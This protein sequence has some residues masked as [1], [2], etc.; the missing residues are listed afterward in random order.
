MSKKTEAWALIR[1]LDVHLANRQTECARLLSLR[2]MEIACSANKFPPLARPRKTFL[3]AARV[4]RSSSTSDS[5]PL[6]YPS[7]RF[8]EMNGWAAGWARFYQLPDLQQARPLI[9]YQIFRDE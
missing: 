3:L 9:I 6:S 4:A 1:R 8:P 7:I 2:R 5:S